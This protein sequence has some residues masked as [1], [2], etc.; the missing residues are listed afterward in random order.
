MEWLIEWWPMTVLGPIVLAAAFVYALLKRRRLT[1][2][3][4]QAQHE[5]VE[6]L[7]DKEPRSDPEQP[8]APTREG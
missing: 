1:R 2:E 3:E 4:Q 5:A 7:Y 8:A 6:R